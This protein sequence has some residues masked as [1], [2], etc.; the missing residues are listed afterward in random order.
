MV[1][2]NYFKSKVALFILLIMVTSNI[3]L[4][5]NTNTR[6]TTHPTGPD[7]NNTNP[8]HSTNHPTPT[9]PNIT[10]AK[11]LDRAREVI[12]SKTQFKM[13]ANSSNPLYVWG[14]K[15]YLIQN[16]LQ[17]NSIVEYSDNNNNQIFDQ[18]E[19][20]KTLNLKQYVTWNFSQEEY[21]DS[22][23]MFTLHTSKINQTGFE[24]T[25]VNL[26][27]Y[28]QS[29]TNYM[30]FDII[31]SNWNWSSLNDRIAVIFGFSLLGNQVATNAQIKSQNGFS[32]NNSTND[33]IFIQN[34]SN[35]TIGYLLSS[36]NAL[37]GL[38]NE[39]IKVK[40][41]FEINTVNDSAV[42]IL[43]YPYFGNYLYHDPV[44]GSNGDT[45]HV[46]SELY[47]LLIEKSG[48]L[49]IT[50][51]LSIMSLVAIFFMRRRK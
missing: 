10:F 17:L 47:S 40:N 41:Q 33:G 31:I 15:D 8:A 13:V 38:N 11:G 18:N 34:N 32:H 51:V 16:S 14:D 7:S 48:L 1:N 43:N 22:F 3:A 28:I 26:M 50:S 46:F 45:V 44:I 20:V 42:V 27:Q 21:N 37:K 5:D 19:L 2:V 29:N 49:I 24:N 6:S 36:V 23:V 12:T 35:Q 4:A 9:L 30:K 39:S 25:Q